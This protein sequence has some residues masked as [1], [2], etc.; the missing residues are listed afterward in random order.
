MVKSKI[1]LR[2]VSNVAANKTVLIDLPIGPRYQHIQLQH[3]FAAATIATA[4]ANMLAIRIKAN[5]K[6]QRIFGSGVA[7]GSNQ[8]GIEL[9]DF[10]TLNQPAGSTAFDCTVAN[11]IVTIPI[12]FAEPWRDTPA[13]REALAWPTSAWTSFQIEIDLGTAATP[14]L[15]AFAIIDASPAPSAAPFIAKVFRQ[16]FN[17]SGT[18]FDIATLDRRDYLTQISLYPDSGSSQQTSEVDLRFNSQILDELTTPVRTAMLINRDM[19]PAATGRT[20]NMT[21][22][23][24]EHDESLISNLLSGALNLNGSSDLALT[25]KATNAMSGTIIALVEKI[26]PPE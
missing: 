24:L 16:Q 8:G 3:G 9:R 18:A 1:Q 5:G 17:A 10:N 11:N 13:D 22:V 25:V 7:S 20:A 4:M 6:I 2:N 19:S 21:D 23:V 26:G 14:T 15:T 12:Y